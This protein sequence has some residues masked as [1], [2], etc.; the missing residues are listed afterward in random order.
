MSTEEIKEQFDQIRNVLNVM[1]KELK[2]NKNVPANEY[3][4][5]KEA[6][7][8]MDMSPNTFNKMCVNYQIHPKKF[9]GL[10]YYSIN[11]LKSVF[12]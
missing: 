12:N 1:S 7:K 9:E 2:H 6:H 8:F 5:A 10:H 4:R 11:D 3:L